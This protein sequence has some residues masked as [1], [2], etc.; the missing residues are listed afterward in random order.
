LPAVFMEKATPKGSQNAG[1]PGSRTGPG[2]TARRRPGKKGN[3]PQTAT[4][5]SRARRVAVG[6]VTAPVTECRACGHDLDRMAPAGH[7][8]RVRVD[9]VF[10]TTG[11]TIAA[12]M[13]TC[14]RCRAGTRGAF[15]DDMPG[16]L[17][18][19]PGIVAFAI[20]L[21]T[22]QMLPLKRTARTLKALT[23]R[24]IAE[25]ALPAR[26]TRLHEALA[27]RETA[28]IA[29]LLTG[30][31]PHADETSLRIDRKQHWLHSVSAGNP[32]PKHCHLERGGEAL[33]DIGI[34][35]RYGGVPVHDRRAG[36]V[37]FENCAHAL[38]ATHLL[39]NLAFIEQAH[40]QA[41]AK[42]MGQ[43]LPN[44]C[45]KV[46]RQKNKALGEP[47]CKALRTRYRTVLT[48]AGRELPAPPTRITGQRGRVAK[49]D[50]GNLHEALIKYETGALRCARNPDVP[51]T[52]HRAGRDIRRAKVKQNVSGC[53]R[54]PRYAAACCRI[55]SCLQSMA[56][57]GCNPLAA[58]GI[59]LNGNAASMV[60]KPPQNNTAKQNEDKGGE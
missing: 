27:D 18:Y 21:L 24:A 25:A 56:C 57:Q 31:V 17:R 6:T 40:G 13:K 51:F 9:I 42:R 8:R 48:Q 50:A 4:T 33:R 30:P 59:A 36:Y 32:V 3:G 39:R 12:G 44:T 23:G 7:E 45:R 5:D 43:L 54:T 52:N 41:R 10:E 34:V 47:D 22:A 60:E 19:G 55:T 15:P 28:A 20:H 16:P 58:I 2:E 29:R 14:P 26:L 38:C 1:L 35:P 37:A 46:R 49:S 11:M 53:F